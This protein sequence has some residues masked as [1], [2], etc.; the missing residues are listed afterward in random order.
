MFPPVGNPAGP[1]WLAAFSGSLG[2]QCLALFMSAVATD[3]Q[4][5]A[6]VSSAL[7]TVPPNSS[8]PE[9]RGFL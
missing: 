6:F 3:C 8:F 1:V 9:W 4:L 5:L 7:F 2:P